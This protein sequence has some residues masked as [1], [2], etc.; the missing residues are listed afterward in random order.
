MKSA[1]SAVKIRIQ[2]TTSPRKEALFLRRSS[3]LM[4]LN[5]SVYSSLSWDLNISMR[6]L[7]KN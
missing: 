1:V 5:L 7:S 6:D 4:S 3:S 2:I